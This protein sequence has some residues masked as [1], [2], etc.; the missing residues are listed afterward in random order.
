MK[1]YV[2]VAIILC[3][4]AVLVACS[5]PSPTV[6]PTATS[7]G[8]PASGPTDA[9]VPAL[10]KTWQWQKRVILDSGTEEQIDDPTKYTLTFN[11]DGT[12]AF[13]ADCNQGSGTYVADE[14]GAIRMEAG[15]MTL[16]ECG[17]SSR[18]QDVTN[19]M[20]AVQD[21]RLEDNG[22]TL[23]LVWPAGGPEDYYK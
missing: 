19:M 13:Q 15:P 20:Y 9:N 23:V 1:T 5:T 8:M 14:T 7:G 22:A 2:F 10:H 11:A 21:Y 4:G 16:A 6:A 3:L 17:E 12:Y 18:S